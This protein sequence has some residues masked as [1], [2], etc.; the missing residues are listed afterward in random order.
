MDTDDEVDGIFRE[1]YLPYS[2]RVFSSL[3]Q[4]PGE[5]AEVRKSST[6]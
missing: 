6:R 5:E 1:L 4:S 2:V 3:G